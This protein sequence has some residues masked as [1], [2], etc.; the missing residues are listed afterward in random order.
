MKPRDYQAKAHTAI[1]HEWETAVATAVVL[2]TGTGKTVLFSNVINAR[3]PGRSLVLAHRE[4]LIYQARD[5]IE[6]FTLLDCGIEMADHYV[7]ASLF[8]E[9]PVVVST[10]QTMNAPW[11]DLRRMHRFKPTDFDTVII[12]ECHHSTAQS[13]RKVIDYFRQN[14]KV[15]VLG[16]TATPDRADEEAL[17][18]VFD[19]VAFDYEILDAIHDGWLVPISQQF[20][21]IGGLDF[22]EIRTTAGDLNGGDLAKVMES[23]H[24]MQG[25]VGASIEL[26]GTKRAILF[27][28]SVKQAEQAAEIFNRYRPGMAGWVCG[29]TNKDDRRTALGLFK[30]GKTQ[31]MCN[32]G[33][34]TEG[35]DDAGVEVILNG[36]PTKSRS[37]YAQIAGRGTR[38]LGGLVDQFD[39]A[40]ERKAAIAASAKPM[41]LIVDFVGNSG[42]HKLMSAADI[43]GGKVSEEAIANAIDKAKKD[44]GAVRMDA[45]LSEEEERIKQAIEKAKKDAEQRRIRLV[46]T[47]V[48]YSKKEVNP[49]DVFDI[50]PV[51]AR[52]WDSDRVLSEKQSK[53]LMRQGINPDKLNYTEGRQLVSEMFRRFDKKLCTIKQAALLKKFGYDVKDL[54]LE[55]ASRL[56]TQLKGNNWRRPATPVA[57]PTPTTPQPLDSYAD[58]HASGEIESEPF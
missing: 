8:G 56:I 58:E 20:V 43:L 40:E 46:P 31:V 17:G 3:R 27:A 53:M 1:N 5:T 39:T 6:R 22:S 55:D 23:E 44:G 45:A 36:R 57:A 52:G 16:V 47:K 7:N 15:R 19:T 34:L 50:E 11:G 41:C 25:V 4:E 37:L 42:K 24:N 9:M 21:S 48:S 38:P 2:P 35:F 10:I 54:K 29:E 49:F 12:D 14:P 51:K 13:Y 18:Q 33:V 26:I 30:D 32:C 28:C